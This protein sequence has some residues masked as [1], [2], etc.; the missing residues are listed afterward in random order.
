MEKISRILL[1]EDDDIDARKIIRT[2]K[3]AIGDHVEIEWVTDSEMGRIEIVRN[4]YDV[5][6]V[7]YRLGADDGV[8]LIRLAVNF[9]CK[10]PLI[11]LTGMSTGVVDIV[12][13]EGGASDYLVKGD[14]TPAILTKSIGYAVVW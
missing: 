6:L 4:I 13:M 3:S 10:M 5:C 8:E 11:L 12:A 14:L 2:I 9:G 7:D 1:I